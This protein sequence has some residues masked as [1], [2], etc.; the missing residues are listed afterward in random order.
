MWMAAHNV[1]R[2]DEAAPLDAAQP[3][4]ALTAHRDGRR[5][6]SLPVRLALRRILAAVPGDLKATALCFVFWRLKGRMARRIK[7]RL[8]HPASG[9]K[10]AAR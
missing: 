8:L 6:V 10:N 4:A 9:V 2:F 5:A 7:Y 3:E 1:S